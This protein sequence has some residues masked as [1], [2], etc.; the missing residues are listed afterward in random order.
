MPFPAKKKQTHRERLLEP[1]EAATPRTLMVW[2][3]DPFYPK[4]ERGRRP[5]GLETCC[6][7]TSCMRCF[8]LSDEGT[9]DTL[10]G[11][12]SIRV[13]ISV[14]LRIWLRCCT[15]GTCCSGRD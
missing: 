15:S 11:S 3:L 6:A 13:F 7:C 10:Y 14:D 5:I 8:G 1:V 2:L 9:E 12:Q 4:G